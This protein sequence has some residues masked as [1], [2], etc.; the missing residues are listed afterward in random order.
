M[1]CVDAVVEIVHQLLGQDQSEDKV[2]QEPTELP[3]L[4]D[5]ERAGL[6]AAKSRECFE[7][8]SWRE[9]GEERGSKVLTPNPLALHPDAAFARVA[10]PEVSGG[11]LAPPVLRRVAEED[12]AIQ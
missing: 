12:P 4:A 7:H 9:V 11:T 10:A 1:Q 5:S 2:V 3:H 6:R 8:L